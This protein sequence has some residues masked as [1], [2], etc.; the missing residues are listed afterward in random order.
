[1]VTTERICNLQLSEDIYGTKL[2]APAVSSQQFESPYCAE[3]FRIAD[4][5][6][7]CTLH[8]SW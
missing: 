3:A 5:P 2:V 6:A 1:V 8:K 7:L 4:L